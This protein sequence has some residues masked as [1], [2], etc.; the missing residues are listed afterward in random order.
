MGF[1]FDY[2]DV[3]V[4]LNVTRDHLEDCGIDTIEQMATLKRAI[5]S[6][7]RGAVVLNADNPRCLAMAPFPATRRLCLVSTERSIQPLQFL[8]AR[9]DC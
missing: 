5:A 6:R 4:C 7:A 3:A 1:G 9:C 8:A 2:C